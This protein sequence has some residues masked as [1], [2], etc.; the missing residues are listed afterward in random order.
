[1]AEATGTLFAAGICNS[2]VFVPDDPKTHDKAREM[3]KVGVP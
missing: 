3:F 1:M 2:T